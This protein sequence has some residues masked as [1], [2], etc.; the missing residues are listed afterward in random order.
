MLSNHTYYAR[1]VGQCI[2]MLRSCRIRCTADSVN[3]GSGYS[4][5]GPV[6]DCK[7][8]LVSFKTHPKTRQSYS[9]WD[10]P[11]P[12]HVYPQVSLWVTR[13]VGSN[14]RCCISALTYMVAFRYV[15]VNRKIFTF[16]CDGLFSMNWLA[17]FS[18]RGSWCALPQS[19]NERQPRAALATVPDLDLAGFIVLRGNG[20]T[21]SKINDFW[22]TIALWL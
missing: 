6:L 21:P 13:P 20:L 1:L 5:S 12:I 11:G 2:L 19:D 9:C 10:K 14:L 3:N 8:W 7:C 4:A 15:T 16:E 17:L 22:S 18:N